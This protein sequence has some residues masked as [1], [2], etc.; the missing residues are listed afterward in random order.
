MTVEDEIRRLQEEHLRETL[1]FVARLR[2]R[3]HS[4]GREFEEAGVTIGY[5][6]ESDHLYI[7]IG[8]ARE[9]V[10]IFV[11]SIVIRVNPDNED[12]ILS[13][14]IPMCSLAM[15]TPELARLR[16]LLPLLRLVP[17]MVVPPRRAGSGAAAWWNISGRVWGACSRL[18]V[19]RIQQAIVAA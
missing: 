11:G 6:R 1:A 13:L 18:I 15:K 16:L 5:I 14:E 4:L 7:T 8:K 9:G 3:Q 2:E 17:R 10:A 19:S 12:D